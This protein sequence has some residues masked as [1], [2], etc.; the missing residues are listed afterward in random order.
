MENLQIGTP[1]K[2]TSNCGGFLNRETF[3][4]EFGKTSLN[5]YI[6]N[7]D[8]NK[9][10]KY[11]ITFNKGV[12]IIWLDKSDFENINESESQQKVQ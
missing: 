1:I 11:E 12:S 2:I 8:V 9:I 10:N 3:I 4:N 5:G 6:S 7:I